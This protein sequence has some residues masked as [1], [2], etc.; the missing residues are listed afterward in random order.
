M[1]ACRILA[2]SLLSVAIWASSASAT[3]VLKVEVP[4]MT[5]TSEWVVLVRVVGSEN[6]DLRADGRGIFTDVTLDVIDVYKGH[7]VPD[8]YVMRLMGG[9]GADGISMRIPGMPRFVRGEEA[10]LDR[11][12]LHHGGSQ[13]GA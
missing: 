7:A 12:S 11:A 2:V 3:T 4:A 1:S 6:V 8:R 5:Q 13:G 9:Q 10:V